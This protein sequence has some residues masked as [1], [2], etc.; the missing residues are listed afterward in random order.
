[1]RFPWTT[2]DFPLATRNHRKDQYIT[3]LKL[4]LRFSRAQ[5]LVLSFF[6][7][8]AVAATVFAFLID[9]TILI[10]GLFWLLAFAVF[11]LIM[12]I[13][14]LNARMTRMYRNTQ[15]PIKK[16]SG[17]APSRLNSNR[18][19]ETLERKFSRDNSAQTG[20]PLAKKLLQEKGNIS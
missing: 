15:V 12:L 9:N 5:K 6:L 16:N 1:A 3:M 2:T 11:I 19:I 8:I 17:K 18:S 14:R 4:F 10:I 7:V 13:R 20:L